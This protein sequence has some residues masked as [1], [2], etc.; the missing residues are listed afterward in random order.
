L[1][2][3]A[4]AVVVWARWRTGDY[5]HPVAL[6]VGAWS[7]SLGLFLLRMLPYPTLP[8]STAVVLLLGAG[9]LVA[10]MFLARPLTRRSAPRI[11]PIAKPTVWLVAYA[12]LGLCGTAWYIWEIHRLLGLGALL[13]DATRIRIALAR[14]EIPSRF[15]FLQF[16]CMIAPLLATGLALGG[17]RLRA[18][19]W[20]LVAL[21]AGATWITTDRT[22]F[23]TIVL[24]ALFMF[25]A[26]KGRE[27][28]GLELTGAVALAGAALAANFLAVGYWTGRT[29]GNLGFSLSA[30]RVSAPALR[31]AA[32]RAPGA[33]V[34]ALP[35]TGVGRPTA[36]MHL[37]AGAQDA[38]DSSLI[39]PPDPDPRGGLVGVVLRKGSTLYLY[40]T[41][42]YAAFA[43]WYPPSQPL[44]HGV[45]ALYPVA[46]LLNR[47]GLLPGPLPS[48]VLGFSTIVRRGTRSILFN[49]YTF[50]YYPLQ[51]FGPAGMM[52]YCLIV[53]LFAGLV[54][55][56]TRRVRGSPV[57]LLLMGQISV[58]LA[59][60][61]FVN[62]FNST[63]AWYL[64]VATTAPFWVSGLACS[65]R[66]RCRPPTAD[67][68]ADGR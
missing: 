30:P 27:G 4:V 67:A 16:F 26:R 44:T 53:G 6:V 13:H 51:D 19:H 37:E 18:W 58:G 24:T 62:K 12:T 52:A 36:P 29:P 40:A 38:P 47:I 10:G 64:A 11:W 28:S 32:R 59:L 2:A 21:C 57:H 66:G 60:S 63:T 55:E 31:A 48:P 56:R 25:L 5:A 61:I 7:L 9:S 54:Y 68:A 8:G 14:Y 33:A 46:R 22:Q 49:G 17:H 50:L 3:L 1:G 15:L 42:S 35:V 34:P 20:G 41:G 39:D 45:H 23:F 43:L 65:W